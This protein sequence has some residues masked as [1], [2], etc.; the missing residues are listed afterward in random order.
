MEFTI[1]FSENNCKSWITKYETTKAGRT[2]PCRYSHLG[3]AL[4][5][6]K[7]LRIKNNPVVPMKIIDESNSVYFIYDPI[8][9]TSFMRVRKILTN[10]NGLKE[11]SGIIDIS[12]SGNGYPW[13]SSYTF[14]DYERF[15]PTKHSLG[16]KDPSNQFHHELF[17]QQV[18][19][20][21][22]FE[23]IQKRL[24]DLEQKE[25]VPKT[26]V[27]QGKKFEDYFGDHHGITRYINSESDSQL[28]II[29]RKPDIINT[30]KFVDKFN[31]Q[32]SYDNLH[33]FGCHYGYRSSRINL[34]VSNGLMRKGSDNYSMA[35]QMLKSS[36]GELIFDVISA[37]LSNDNK[38]QPRG[39]VF[40]KNWVEERS[41]NHDKTCDCL[42][43]K[44]K[45][46]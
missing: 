30:S 21:K 11:C 16:P 38:Q 41:K 20:M 26:Y 46:A 24:S 22:Q 33:M 29:A 17:K 34:I 27:Q 35:H 40:V 9:D 4:D 23:V 6:L 45:I 7:E 13:C 18:E 25:T 10:S 32:L 36:T 44:Q 15:D 39:E 43:C 14:L 19:I 12:D 2:I 28:L 42:T 37:K 3:K 1:L 5:K 31:F 8:K